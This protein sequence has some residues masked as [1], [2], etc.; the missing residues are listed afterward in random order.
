MAELSG[1]KAYWIGKAHALAEETTCSRFK[2]VKHP[3]AI[4]T[5]ANTRSQFERVPSASARTPPDYH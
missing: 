1:K 5:G 4:R 3:F 2:Q